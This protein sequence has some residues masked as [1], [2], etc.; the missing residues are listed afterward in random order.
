MVNGTPEEVRAEVERVVNG[1]KDGGGYILSPGHPVL[2]D[3]V[4]TENI[5]AMYQAGH[6][7]GRYEQVAAQCKK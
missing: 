4:P 3:D 1:C 7:F 6:E 5:I 2:Q